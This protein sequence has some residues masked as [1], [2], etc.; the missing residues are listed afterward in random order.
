MAEI[1]LIDD[2]H[3]MHQI[4][5]LFLED[6]G[7]RVHSAV[8]GPAGLELASRA[9]PDLILLDM[10]MPGMDGLETLHELKDSLYTADI[11]VMIFSVLD[12]E[13][14]DIDLNEQ[15][16]AGY[17]MKPVDMHT[18]QAGVNMALHRP[19]HLH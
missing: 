16:L 3:S 15:G 1:L 4:V 18:L 7:H 12:R 17:L 9:H 8:S 5:N 11:P 13:N 2:D 6:T 10:A 19:Y 14:L